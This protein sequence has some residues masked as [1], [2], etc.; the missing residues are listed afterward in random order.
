MQRA[1]QSG[2][3]ETPVLADRSFGELL[4]AIAAETPAPGGG[5][6]AAYAGALA[7]ALVE[8]SAKFTL[9]RESY[10]DRHPRMAS[11]NARAQA[12]R[13]ELVELGER[14]LEAYAPVLETLRLPEAD[15]ERAARLR[16]A[17]SAAAQS[18]LAVARAAAEVAALGAETA[19]GGNRHLAGD[20][21]T[22][23]LLAEAACQAAAALVEINLAGPPGD[24]RVSEAA[25]LAHQAQNSR[26]KALQFG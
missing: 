4:E 17:L 16:A 24:A 9:V 8:M 22:G 7:A 15:T 18:P 14:D 3:S 26:E 12:L 25:E 5:C 19:E 20:A 2:C 1:G 11:I 13:A 21:I 6:A 10:S 23:A